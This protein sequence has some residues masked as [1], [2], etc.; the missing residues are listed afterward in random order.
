MDVYQRKCCDVSY[1]ISDYETQK[2]FS[3]IVHSPLWEKQKGKEE[4]K[5]PQK[6]LTL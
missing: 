6:T 3:E 5:F 2:A 4:T 1:I